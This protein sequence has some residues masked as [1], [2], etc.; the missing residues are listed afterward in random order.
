MWLTFREIIC[1]IW[2]RG[3]HQSVKSLCRH[4]FVHEK[5]VRW[6][7]L[8][9]DL[10]QGTWCGTGGCWETLSFMVTNSIMVNVQYWQPF[11]IHCE[12]IR[13]YIYKISCLILDRADHLEG[14]CV[15]GQDLCHK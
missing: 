12:C 3:Y 8:D 9:F 14:Y 4:L 6:S 10:V 11:V 1:M 13:Y 2:Y 5:D 7:Y 15:V